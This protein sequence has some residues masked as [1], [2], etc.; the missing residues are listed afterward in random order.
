MAT[1][2]LTSRLS[3]FSPSLL[4]SAP[5][6]SQLTNIPTLAQLQKYAEDAKDVI[7]NS[8]PAYFTSSSSELSQPEKPDLILAGHE[9]LTKV[10]ERPARVVAISKSVRQ[11]VRPWSNSSP[12]VYTMSDP[13]QDQ[14]ETTVISSGT[15]NKL[16]EGR[17][18]WKR[19]QG[20]IPGETPKM[21]SS[22]GYSGTL[23]LKEDGARQG[24]ER[25]DGPG[26]GWFG[27]CVVFSEPIE[28]R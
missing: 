21:V 4:S 13:R 28:L 22:R 17:E 5:S 8:A 11:P 18:G 10:V 12:P 7:S 20:D 25:K 15:T 26:K 27:W 19:V 2:L 3:P 6:P 24:G 23:M 9:R 1:W 14:S 16:K